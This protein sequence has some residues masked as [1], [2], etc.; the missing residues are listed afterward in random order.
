[1]FER[2]RNV[3]LPEFRIPEAAYRLAPYLRRMIAPLNPVFARV[4]ETTAPAI[5][6]GKAWYEKREAR[7]KL[8]L[9]ML[10]VVIAVLIIYGLIYSPIVQL[11]SDL[12]DRVSARRH[13]LLEV[14]SLAR[15]YDRLKTQVAI[16]QK[17]T[18]TA[19][20]DFSLFSVIEQTLT[21]S[22]GRNRIGSLTP[23]D[24]SVPGGFRQYSVDIKL[25]G[26]SLPQIVDT[27]YGVQS[28]AL[29]VTVSD[30]QIHERASDSHTYDVDMTCVALGRDG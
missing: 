16:A 2:V 28:L 26:L 25:N 11:R 15:T 8:L 18:V 27:L 1:M 22:V 7:E 30:L 5:E 21:K 12:S 19:G 9:R 10:G 6:A 13:D 23:L 20:R 29:P 17:R 14:R 3:A 4:K 24:R